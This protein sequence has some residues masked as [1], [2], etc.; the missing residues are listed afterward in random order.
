VEEELN[1]ISEDGEKKLKK[2]ERV[3]Y[4]VEKKINV[5]ED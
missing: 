2:M 4:K 1:K 5:I 3:M